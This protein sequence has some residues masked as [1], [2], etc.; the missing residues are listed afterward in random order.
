MSKTKIFVSS[1]CYDLSQVR[2]DIRNCLLDLGH[3]PYLSDYSSFPVIP[4]LTITENCSR[5]VRENT[6][7]FILIIGGRYGS[8][9]KE[10]NK[11]ITNIEYNI[12]KEYG[13]ESFIFV[14][15]SIYKILPL[16]EKNDSADFSD[17]VDSTEVFKFI[18][19]INSEQKWIFTFDKASDIINIIKVQLS[20]YLKYLVDKKRGNKLEPLADFQSESLRARQIAIDKPKYWEYFL[21]EE[22]LRVKLQAIRE[23][24]DDFYNGL[25]YR[26]YQLIDRATF[27]NTKFGSLKDFLHYF[28][29]AAKKLEKSW[30]ELGVSG[31]PIEIKKAVDKFI[32]GCIYL[33]EWEVDLKYD[34]PPSEFDSLKSLFQGCAFEMFEQV[35]NLPKKLM[36]P[37]NE[38]NPQGEYEIRIKIDPPSRINDIDKEIDRLRNN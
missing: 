9:D 36:E 17:Y 22:L 16:W 7:I 38:P 19:G 24:F 10:H 29:F 1:T 3:Q 28:E 5:N 8:L 13:I 23:N 34:I 15:E 37:F 11:S 14:S 2:D 18:K 26:K 25:Y 12:S 32:T 21:T 27:L 30:G 6:D 31:N 33:F 4:D 20:F 35:E